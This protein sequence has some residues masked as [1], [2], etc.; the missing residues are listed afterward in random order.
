MNSTA[1]KLI[2]QLLSLQMNIDEQGGIE[3]NGI[4]FEEYPMLR[5]KILSVFGLPDSN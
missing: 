5:A 2:T 1:T 3:K 4:L